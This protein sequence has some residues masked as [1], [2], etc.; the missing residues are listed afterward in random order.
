[1]CGGGTVAQLGAMT[2]SRKQSGRAHLSWGLE[3][4]LLACLPL[5]GGGTGADPNNRSM[6][7]AG[8]ASFPFMWSPPCPTCPLPH[9]SR[10]ELARALL[11]FS[12]MSVVLCTAEAGSVP[13]AVLINS[14][15]LS[16]CAEIQADVH[17]GGRNEQRCL[18]VLH[19]TGNNIHLC[20]CLPNP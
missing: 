5:P 13:C 18:G 16:V 2:D 4:L 19:T 3:G 12:E 17:R 20:F 14:R 8:D 7:C 9:N 11:P 10:C 6:L 15:Y 1:M